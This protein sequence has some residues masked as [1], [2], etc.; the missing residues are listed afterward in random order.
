MAMCSKRAGLG[1]VPVWP[2]GAQ[3]GVVMVRC[4][5]CHGTGWRP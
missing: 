2:Q 4:G 1:R 3:G 5:A